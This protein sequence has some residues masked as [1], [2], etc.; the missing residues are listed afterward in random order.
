MLKSSQIKVKC[1][2]F[3]AFSRVTEKAFYNGLHGYILGDSVLPYRSA[4]A[5]SEGNAVIES[6]TNSQRVL[7][8]I[9]CVAHKWP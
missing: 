4:G 3:V 5:G 9:A 1:L 6:R 8:S 7:L 2:L